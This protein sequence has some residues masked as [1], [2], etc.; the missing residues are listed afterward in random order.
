M[1]GLSDLLEGCRVNGVLAL[2]SEVSNDDE[3]L[4]EFCEL[5]L[6][7]LALF[8]GIRALESRSGEGSFLF[9]AVGV[10]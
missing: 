6:N 1:L 4:R 10:V 3:K 8:R 2:R 5:L 9:V 7:L